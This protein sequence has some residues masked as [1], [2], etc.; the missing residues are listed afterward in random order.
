[1]KPLIVIWILVLCTSVASAQSSGLIPDYLK[2]QYAGSIGF[3]S[4]GP[5]YSFCKTRINTDFMYGYVPYSKGGPLR[6]VIFRLITNPVV[7][8]INKSLSFV[9]ISVSGFVTY[10]FGDQFFVRLPSYYPEEYYRWS[11]AVRYHAGIG[12]LLAYKNKT[13]GHGLALYYEFNTN[14]L[15]LKSMRANA[16]IRLWDILSLGIGIKVY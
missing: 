16:S 9:P 12:S 8:H 5:G 7:I 15:Y 10:H 4:A 3:I 11:S 13:S 2:I 6:I 14:D 1:M